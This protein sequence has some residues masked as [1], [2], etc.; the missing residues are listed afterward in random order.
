MR[1]YVFEISPSIAAFSESQEH[2]KE[3]VRFFHL[4]YDLG[5]LEDELK[6]MRTSVLFFS[7]LI[8]A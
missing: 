5:A 7:G 6:T 2:T 3:A 8:T 4:V 1:W